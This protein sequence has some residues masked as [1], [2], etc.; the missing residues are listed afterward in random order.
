MEGTGNTLLHG[1]VSG[2]RHGV[3]VSGDHNQIVGVTAQD[4]RQRGFFVDGS[5]N[6][7]FVNCVA[8]RNG[9]HGFKILLGDGN[10]IRHSEALTN[11]RD[12]IEIEEGNKNSVINN[13]AEHNG[14][15]DICLLF[16]AP[17]LYRPWFYAGIDILAGSENNK[18]I[19]NRTSGNTGCTAQ[20]ADGPCEEPLRDRNLWD[21]NV[22]EVTGKCDSTNRWHNNREDGHKIDPE[23]APGPQ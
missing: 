20:D 18:V 16:V 8:T 22:D 17:N 3:R 11:C 2:C 9:Q 12:G 1:M 13:H 10:H 14:N 19:N 23:C 5:D 15:P 21:E 6:N 4:N 7:H